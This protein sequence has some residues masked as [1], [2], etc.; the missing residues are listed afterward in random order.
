MFVRLWEICILQVLIIIT[1]ANTFMLTFLITF[2]YR[3][4]FF[5]H[6]IDQIVCDSERV[7]WYTKPDEKALLMLKTLCS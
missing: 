1:I 3:T 7:T 5:S 6:F 2:L 4:I